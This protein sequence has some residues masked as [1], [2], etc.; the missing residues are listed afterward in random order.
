MRI[1]M[2]PAA[3]PSVVENIA[4]WDGSASWRPAGYLLA[5]LTDTQCDIGWTVSNLL[6]APDGV[7]CAVTFTDPNPPPPP[8]QP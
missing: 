4:E 3:N 1:A 8:V 6:I 7:W 5:E 2:I